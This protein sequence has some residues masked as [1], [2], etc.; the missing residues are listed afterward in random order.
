LLNAIFAGL[1]YL[2][3]AGVPGM[4]F[5]A[6]A[7][8]T[9]QAVAATAPAAPPAAHVPWYQQPTPL[10]VEVW[11]LLALAAALVIAYIAG[12]VLRSI[13]FALAK[14]FEAREK[15]FAAIMLR[16]LAR[17]A[18][19]ALVAIGL[20]I[21]L[22]LLHLPPA[23][24][25]LAAT[26]N[27]VMLTVVLAYALFCMVD[28]VDAWLTR[29]AVRT[30]SKL[31]DM[32]VPMVRTT[33]RATI[34]VLAIVQITTLLSDKPM[35]SVIAG[36]GVGGL[37]IG[38]AG[39]ETVKNFFGSLTIFADRPF[40][41]GS[42]IEACGETGTVETVGFRS[43]RIR[44]PD[45]HVV[46]IPNGMLAG[47]KIKNIAARPYMKRTLTLGVTYDTTPE[48]LKE[49]VQ[50]VRDL[51]ASREGMHPDFPPRV[52]FSDFQDSALAIN[53]I[54]WFTPADMWQF[55]AYNE[56]LN[57]EILTRFN[58]AGIAF[59]FPSRTIYMADAQ[60]EV[61]SAKGNGEA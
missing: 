32:I 46:T 6:D 7:E 31:D 23:L 56:W 39:Q 55:A 9:E 35:T 50:M 16:T 54:Y 37:A 14:R 59:A 51:L 52:F 61:D 5:A 57:F 8:S 1:S 18:V 12:N 13:F 22:D 38:L 21:G 43:T 19:I 41:I 11:R 60:T 36:L 40:E 58:G 2:L 3:I 44:T 20:R 26:V 47:D 30:E 15:T 4:A 24:L 49:A 34:V 17:S 53:V 28:L 33:L 25:G 29:V 48:K 27:G 42:L 10:G 45:G